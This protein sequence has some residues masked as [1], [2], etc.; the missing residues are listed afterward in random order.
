LDE[1]SPEYTQKQRV[2]KAETKRTVF[3][4]ENQSN[5]GQ[6][7]MHTRVLEAQQTR[8]MI[9]KRRRYAK[10]SKLNLYAE[11]AKIVSKRV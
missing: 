6:S 3:I 11:T 7:T 10:A 5:K 9:S 2:R 8:A 4:K 1:D